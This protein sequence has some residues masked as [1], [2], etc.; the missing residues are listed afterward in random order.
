[1]P[2]QTAQ[3]RQQETTPRRAA[4][5]PGL[6]LRPLRRA[7]ARYT[8]FVAWMKLLLPVFAASVVALVVIWP[9]LQEKPEA[10]RLG[11]SSIS[12]HEKSG[13]QVVNARFT[14]SDAEARPF[15]VTADSAIQRMD[16]GDS[17]ELELPKADISMADGSWIAV[18]AETGTYYKN[19]QILALDGGVNM[20]HDSGFEFRTRKAEIDLTRGTARGQDPVSGHGPFGSLSASGFMVLDH[21]SRIIFTGKA[22]LEFFPEPGPK[23][24]NRSR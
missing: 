8:R 9:Q 22:K 24:G 4:E 23:P 5:A 3:Y 14:G 15:T 13:Q 21:G 19:K 18:A 6:V 20:F 1:M 10:F 11:L 16:T 17:F 12:I 2:E 7:G